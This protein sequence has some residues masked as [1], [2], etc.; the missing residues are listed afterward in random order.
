MCIVDTDV[1]HSRYIPE[2][3]HLPS[4][5]H[6]GKTPHTISSGD[7]S[8]F[9]ALICSPLTFCFFFGLV[10]FLLPQLP[11]H[12]CHHVLHCRPSYTIC[13]TTSLSSFLH[14][15]PI[16]CALWHHRHLPHI[17]MPEKKTVS[18]KKPVS[19]APPTV[20]PPAP[21]STSKTAAASLPPPPVSEM[22]LVKLI[23]LTTSLPDSPLG[24]VWKHAFREGSKDGF[25]R[26]TVLFKGKDVKQAFCEVQMKD[27]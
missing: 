15:S 8:V 12:Q 5:L 10:S 21:V 11:S 3:H 13:L 19:Q 4:P 9:R 26:G 27:R 1:I 18:K 7:E 23:A 6:A 22:S 25:R 20:L 24:L 17:T 2:D 16:R 14:S